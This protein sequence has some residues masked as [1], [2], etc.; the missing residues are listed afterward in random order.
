[1]LTT[2][3]SQPRSNDGRGKRQKK[4]GSHEQTVF[5][6]HTFKCLDNT[7]SD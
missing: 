6:L 4:H 3:A 2:A 1:M 5:P 7:G